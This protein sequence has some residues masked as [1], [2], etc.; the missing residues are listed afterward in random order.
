MA[1]IVCVALNV[2]RKNISEK[3]TENK[4]GAKALGRGGFR[5]LELMSPKGP[6]FASL[7]SNR[8]ADGF[9]RRNKTSWKSFEDVIPLDFLFG[10]D[11]IQKP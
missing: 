8:A 1:G 6:S 7:A 2:L 3:K 10:N 11:Y 9:V 4:C 5:P